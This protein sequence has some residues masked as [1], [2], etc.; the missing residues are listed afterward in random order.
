MSKNC[1]KSK[2]IKSIRRDLDSLQSHLEPQSEPLEL[3]ESDFSTGG[4]SRD[5]VVRGNLDHKNYISILT[6]TETEMM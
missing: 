3:S 2:K 4:N 1:Y 5:I 6:I